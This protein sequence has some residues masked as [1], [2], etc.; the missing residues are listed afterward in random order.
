MPMDAYGAVTN[1]NGKLSENVDIGIFDDTAE[2]SLV[3]WG[4]IS[5]SVAPWRASQTILL[6]TS[7]GFRVERRP[8]LSVTSMTHVDIDPLMKDAEWLRKVAQRLTKKECVNP[9]VPEG[10]ESMV[11]LREAV[12]V[13]AVRADRERSFR[14]RDGAQFGKEDSVYARGSR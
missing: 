6:L 12:T 11:W 13:D 4:P 14:C 10:G 1:K 8:Q 5:A 9:A 2:A 7:P 3:L